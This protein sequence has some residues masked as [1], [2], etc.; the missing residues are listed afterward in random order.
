MASLLFAGPIAVGDG[1]AQR[2]INLAHPLWSWLLPVSRL[3]VNVVGLAL[4]YPMIKAYPYVIVSVGT[5]GTAHY[6]HLA[7]VYNGSFLWGVLSW[8]WGYLLISALVYAWY[9]MP[10][11]RRLFRRQPNQGGHSRLLNGIV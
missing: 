9:C 4:Q 10:H 11:V 6:S 2:A 8:M 1:V 7:L 5:T 3:F